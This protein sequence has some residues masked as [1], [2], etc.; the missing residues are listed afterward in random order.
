MTLTTK[1]RQWI[2]GVGLVLT[3]AAMA[4]LEG[5]DEP[6]STVVQP[7]KVKTSQVTKMTGIGSELAGEIPLAK[8]NRQPLPEDVK[9]MFAGKTWIV[10]PPPP[11]PV[12]P[13]PPS[14]PPLPYAYRGKLAE[15]GEKVAV[16]L[17]KQ[18]RSY[19]V[20]EG[21]VIDKVYRVEEVRPPVMTLTYLPLNIKQSIPIGE[22]N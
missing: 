1:Q 17:T 20:R 19:V 18:G 12:P 22:L 7:G 10:T 5:K 2:L 11:K 3:L 4:A 8:L 16:F 9:E 6:D 13:A 21:E 15:E 14:A